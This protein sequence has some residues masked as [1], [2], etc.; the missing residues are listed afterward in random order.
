MLK[1]RLMGTP[2]D[3][4]WY[5]NHL[6]NSKDMEVIEF[7]ELFSIKG[8]KSYFRAYVEVCDSVK[9]SCLA[10]QNK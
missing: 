9:D 5:R 2:K 6:E 1:I 7:S 3:I 8:S 4:Q 10:K